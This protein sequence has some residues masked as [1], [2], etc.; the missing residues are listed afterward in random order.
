MR[1]THKINSRRPHPVHGA[2]AFRTA[3]GLWSVPV[4]GPVNTTTEYVRIG[5][6]IYRVIDHRVE[7]GRVTG[8]RVADDPNVWAVCNPAVP[9]AVQPVTRPHSEKESRALAESVQQWA[10]SGA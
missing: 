1:N 8:V 9:N 4:P 3:D 10:P 7:V 6:R 2:D 5:S